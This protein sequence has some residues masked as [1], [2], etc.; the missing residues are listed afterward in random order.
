MRVARVAIHEVLAVGFLLD[1]EG[2]AFTSARLTTSAMPRSREETQI[3][4]ARLAPRASRECLCSR[5]T[6]NCFACMRS[7]ARA[8]GKNSHAKYL[9][10]STTNAATRALRSRRD[11]E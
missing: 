2:V 11:I 4:E 9:Y 3:S 1:A 7:R 10:L 6:E 5:E 8:P